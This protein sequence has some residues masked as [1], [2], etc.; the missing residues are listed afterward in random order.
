MCLYDMR[1]FLFIDE[2]TEE[3]SPFDNV[4]TRLLENEVKVVLRSFAENEILL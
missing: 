2:T 3:G 4:I 1:Y